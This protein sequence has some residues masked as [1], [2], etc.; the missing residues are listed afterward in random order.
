MTGF[1]PFKR[2]LMG[3]HRST[4]N[5]DAFKEAAEI[6]RYLKI[7][8]EGYLVRDAA[9]ENA[10]KLPGLREFQSI[11]QH[12]VPMDVASAER[13]ESA[14]AR[15]LERLVRE[16][17]DAAQVASRFETVRAEVA[18]TIASLSET[19]DILLLP[20]P[21][22]GAERISE[23]YN[24]LYKAA[25]ASKAALLIVPRRG[26]RPGGPVL[27]VSRGQH[28]TGTDAAKIISTASGRKLIAAA[29]DIQ[30]GLP[31]SLLTLPAVGESMIVLSR[32]KDDQDLGFDW[33]DF[34]R[35]RRAAVLLV[36]RDV[37]EEG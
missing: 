12:W 1:T 32:T 29:E 8:L 13:A 27:S 19:G 28:D 15:H 6:A 23:P 34:A 14:A 9:L 7:G 30:A 37:T 18:Q 3:F 16:I 21:G 22:S 36:A 33:I 20:E 2:V 4:V 31:R 5:Q 10:L 17:A 11:G 25:L 35:S 24:Q 26:I